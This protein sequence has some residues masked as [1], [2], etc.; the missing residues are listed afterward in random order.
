[1]VAE[2]KRFSDF[3]EGHHPLDGSKVKL[4]DILNTEILVLD[5]R[6]V[7]SKY[8]KTPCLTLQFQVGGEKHILFTGSTVL[9]EQIETYK[10]KLPFYATI[11]KIDRY[12]TFS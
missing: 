10:D 12:Y 7:A 8:G 1:M 9:A 4:E 2:P 6:L 11:K 5:Y 3:A